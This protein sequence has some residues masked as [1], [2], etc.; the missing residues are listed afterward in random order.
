MFSANRFRLGGIALVVLAWACLAA[1]AWS[2][3]VTVDDPIVTEGDAG[4]IDAVFTVTL[5]T[6][7]AADVTVDYQTLPGLPADPEDDFLART[8]QLTWDAE[9]GETDGQ[10]SKT[11]A[12]PVVGDDVDEA[13][14]YF[15]LEVM[16]QVDGDLTGTATI[17]DTDATISIAD[18]EVYEGSGGTSAAFTV[19]ASSTDSGDITVGYATADGTATSPSDYTTRTG[20]LTFAEFGELTQTITVPVMSDLVVEPDELFLVNLTSP[21]NAT[22]ADGT[23]QGRIRDGD[24]PAPPPPPPP[25]PPS[26]DPGVTG[27]TSNPTVQTRVLRGLSLQPSK[28]RVSRNALVRLNGMLRASGGPVSCRSRQ[29]IAIQRRKQTGGRFQ[30]FEVAITTR[31]G[32]FR[33]STRPIRTYA[34]RA[35]VSQTTRCMGATSKTATVVVRKR[36]K[37]GSAHR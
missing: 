28:R 11:V 33:S 21:T 7:E 29:K 16:G 8:G 26:A 9:T 23:G 37:G 30:T 22:I 19:T 10:T 14:E 18:V 34:Y 27:D 31:S 15:D 24:A 17:L 32:S 2:A 3:T 25:P 13:T 4:N 5:T 1:P 35:R 6:V 12:V 36:S 20:T